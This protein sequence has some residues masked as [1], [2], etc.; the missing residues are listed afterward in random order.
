MRRTVAA[1]A[2]APSRAAAANK[3]PAS[4]INESGGR[5]ARRANATADDSSETTPPSG[6]E[7]TG[8]ATPWPPALRSHARVSPF[9]FRLFELVSEPDT[10]HICRWNE[11]GDAFEV[12]DETR[13]A[14]EV[15]PRYFKHHNISS[16]VRQLSTYGFRKSWRGK[17]E[18]SHPFFLRDRQD[19]LV[20]IPRKT[21]R[22]SATAGAISASVVGN[23]LD[24]SL[25]LY[26]RR[27]AKRS[28]SPDVDLVS[29]LGA[30]RSQR[31]RTENLLAMTGVD[32]AAAAPAEA[33]VRAPATAAT[34]TSGAAAELTATEPLDSVAAA[35]CLPTVLREYVGEHISTRAARDATTQLI[36]KHDLQL[37]QIAARL[38]Q[39]T[40]QMR[41][42]VQVVQACRPRDPPPRTTAGGGG[43]A[44]A[45]ATA[46]GASPP[47]RSALGAAIVRGHD[48]HGERDNA[49][50]ASAED[51]LALSTHELASRSI[52]LQDAQAFR[53]G[54]P[55]W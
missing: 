31:L 47:S 33:G 12:A 17:F 16:F 6:D 2:T 28:G 4:L 21:R 53:P 38:L 19:L 1:A 52:Q 26:E 36:V 14:T 8:V 24:P 34:R 13:F 41:D 49:P 22:K 20:H 51:N 23:V 9:V 42:L 55:S 15:L 25:A 11:Q 44:R 32:S 7:L 35:A 48:G 50:H 18:Y 3:P 43:G 27:G 10:S 37:A 40:E 45:A 29:M 39:L 5:S 30:D 46:G 54:S